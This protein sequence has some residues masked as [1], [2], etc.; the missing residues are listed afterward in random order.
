MLGHAVLIGSLCSGYGGL[1]LAA[2][3]HF[4]G[5]TCWLAELDRDACAVLEVRFPG[6]PNLGDVKTVDWSMVPQVDVLT[7][8]YPCQPFSQA[9]QKRGVDDPRHLWPEVLRAIRVLRPRFVVLENVRG[10]LARGFDEVLG[11]LAGCGFDAEWVVLQASDCGAP[12]RR[13]RLFVLAVPN[14]DGQ[15]F[16]GCAGVGQEPAE[17]SGEIVGAAD[18]VVADADGV[19]FEGFEEFDGESSCWVD[20]SDRGYVDRCS[21]EIDADA[22]GEAGCGRTGLSGATERTGSLGGSERT[23]WG[24]FGP[25]IERWER[26]IGRDAPVPLV[27]GT[28]QLNAALVEWMMGL[29]AGWVTDIVPNR[30]ALKTLG[31]GVVPQQALL[32]LKVLDAQRR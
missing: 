8:G 3:Q 1:D 29:P 13:A 32:A 2:E 17:R 26:L 19:R 30:R 16:E 14:A 7:A 10:H 31:N 15:R 9:G 5:R 28:K 20:G 23:D 12:H 21:M 24:R 25:V 11:D 27:P 18:R 4:G 22:D 6:V